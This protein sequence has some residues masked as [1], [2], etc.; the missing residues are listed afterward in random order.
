L[1]VI[2]NSRYRHSLAL[3]TDLCQFTM[4]Q[5]YW[6]LGMATWQASFYHAFRA[7]PFG[8]GFAIACELEQAIEFIKSLQFTEEETAHLASMNGND[9]RPLFGPGFVR[10]LRQLRFACDEA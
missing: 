9:G 2:I 1:A 10:F 8:G 7:N 4:A 6:K 3:L 5:G